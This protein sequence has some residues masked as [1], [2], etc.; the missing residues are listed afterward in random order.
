MSQKLIIAVLALGIL[1]LGGFLVHSSGSAKLGSAGAVFD[2]LPRWFGNALYVG[3]TQQWSVDSSGS[4]TT[5]GTTTMQSSV[6]GTTLG[7]HFAV[8]ATGTPITLY[9]NSGTPKVCAAKPSYLY[10][11]AT[12]FGPSLVFSV[13]TSTGAVPT[14]N[15]MASTT[16]AT[17]TN[18]LV[19][20]QPTLAGAFVL[21]TGDSLVAIVG[22]I[23]NASASSTNY[24]HWGVDFGLWCNNVQI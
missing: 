15:V 11:R 7:G 14:A 8:S 21:G 19:L 2:G 1:V 6:T 4:M 20:A 9:T 17:T 5:T 3:S 18:A 10:T 13:G 16:I 23:A 24:S 12:G 22:D